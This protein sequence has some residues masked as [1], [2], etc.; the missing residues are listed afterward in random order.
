MT[1][2]FANDACRPWAALA[3]TAEEKGGTEDPLE[4]ER[5]A[6]AAADRATAASSSLTTPRRSSRRSPFY[7]DL[8]F[9]DLVFHFRAR[10]RS[11][12]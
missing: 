7:V 11:V 10:I 8:G 12:R 1:P 4:M 5:L 3:L 9:E 2:A 6:E